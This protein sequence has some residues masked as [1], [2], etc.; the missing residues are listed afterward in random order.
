MTACH[1]SKDQTRALEIESGVK[2]SIAASCGSEESL[3]A[4]TWD[5]IVAAAAQDEECCFLSNV[6]NSGFPKTK[7]DLPEIICR[8]WP[9][10]E[11]YYVI[12][13]VI[14]KGSRILIPQQLRAEVLGC[15]HA[16]HQSVNGML[17]NARQRWFWPGLEVNLCQTRVQCKAC[18]AVDP[19]NSREPMCDPPTPHFPFQNTVIVFCEIRGNKYLVFSDQYT[20][21][22][23]VILM[24]DAT[25][26][27][28]CNQ[29]RAR[30]CTCGVPDEMSSDG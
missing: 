1:P 26:N 25:T 29:L 19:S 24:K 30:F 9:A 23:E 22:V 28:V 10:R 13:R 27:Q 11:E 8:F 16:T 5:R 7:D 6:I 4:I 3:R 15:F 18:N 14:L 20:G 2:S 21:W 12:N 17:A